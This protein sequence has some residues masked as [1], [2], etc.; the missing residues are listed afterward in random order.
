[1]SLKKELESLIFIVMGME[2]SALYLWSPNRNNLQEDHFSLGFKLAQYYLKSKG[3]TDKNGIKDPDTIRFGNIELPR[4]SDNFGGYVGTTTGELQILVNFRNGKEPFR[5]F[6]LNDIKTGR[7]NTG[8]II[9][10]IGYKTKLFLLEI[11]LR[12]WEIVCIHWQFPNRK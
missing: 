9:I 4:V 6:S 1:M 8:E 7:T 10:P 5:I 3:I 12:V 11:Y 2:K